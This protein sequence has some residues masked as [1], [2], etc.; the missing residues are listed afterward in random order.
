MKNVLEIYAEHLA[1]NGRPPYND[2]SAAERQRFEYFRYGFIHGING[3]LRE[4]KESQKERCELC[5]HAVALAR[6]T[7]LVSV[8]GLN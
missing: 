5:G 3:A 2:S 4:V 1:A 6:I 7:S 8:H